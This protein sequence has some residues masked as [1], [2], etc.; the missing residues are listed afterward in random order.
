MTLLLKDFRHS[1]NF[2][3]DYYALDSVE[4]RVYYDESAHRLVEKPAGLFAYA[5]FELLAEIDRLL[6]LHCEHCGLPFLPN[7]DGQRY[8]PGTGC[9]E[10]AYQS[11]YARHPHR[12]EYQR[13]YKRYR[14]G[15]ITEQEWQRWREENPEPRHHKEGT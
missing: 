15:T 1:R 6:P 10:A 7:R 9:Y 4:L 5:W 12:R 13:M 14:R 11:Q 2:E 8:C 3:Y